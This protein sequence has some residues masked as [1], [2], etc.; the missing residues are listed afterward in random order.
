MNKKT[1]NFK[2]KATLLLVSSLTVMSGATIAPALPSM[3][4]HFAAVENVEFWIRFVLTTPALFIV[5]AAPIAG[6]IVDRAG[7]RKL[8]L[9]SMVLYAIAG[10]SGIYLESLGAILAGRALLGVAVAGVMTTATT[11]IADYYEGTARAQ[12][13]G[14]QAAFMSFGGVVFLVSGGLLAESG[15]R[16]PFV[17][18]LF[19]LILIPMALAA[20]PEPELPGDEE[21]DKKLSVNGTIQHPFKLLGFIYGVLLLGATVFYFIPLQIPF[22]LEKMTGAGP[23]VSGMSIA[24]STLFG[25]ATSFTYGRIRARFGYV[26]ILGFNF[27]LMGVGYIL[28]GTATGLVPILIG[29]AL[30]GLGMGLMYPNLSFWLTSETSAAIRGRAVAGFTTFIFLGQFISPLASQPFVE[31]FGLGAMFWATG[32]VLGLFAILV[33]LFQRPI[34]SFTVLENDLLQPESAQLMRMNGVPSLKDWDIEKRTTREG[35]TTDETG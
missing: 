25:M 24:V 18:Y 9:P 22:Y 17:I 27:G 11:L 28:I 23:L 8:L 31:L 32:I 30:N 29:L 13:M 14:W 12:I 26:T 35:K 20:L 21:N 10:S 7:R 1:N 4:A 3:Q 19:S 15:W 6:L 5:L 33:L 2:T 16:L 34:L